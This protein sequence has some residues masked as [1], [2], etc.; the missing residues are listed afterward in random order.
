MTIHLRSWAFLAL[1]V[2]PLICG[3][4]SRR[5]AGSVPVES[6]PMPQQPAEGDT[7][8]LATE[9]ARPPDDLDALRTRVVADTTWAGQRVRRCMAQELLPDQEGIVEAALGNLR[10]ARKALEAGDLKRAESNARTARQLAS[11]LRCT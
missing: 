5:W 3:C 10:E 9:P 8:S 2:P 4:S 11:S 7:V 6:R 1:I